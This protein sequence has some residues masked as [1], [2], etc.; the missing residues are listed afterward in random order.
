LRH[1]LSSL[2]ELRKLSELFQ[3]YLHELWSL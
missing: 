3:L 1:E 2:C